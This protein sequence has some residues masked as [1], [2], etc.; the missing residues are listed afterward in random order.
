MVLARHAQP[1]A[2]VHLG[3]EL[4]TLHCWVADQGCCL[5]ELAVC[6]WMQGVASGSACGGWFGRAQGL[7]LLPGVAAAQFGARDGGQR[8]VAGAEPG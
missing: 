2:Y 7:D 3:A 1:R 6:G 4:F 8:G 5:G